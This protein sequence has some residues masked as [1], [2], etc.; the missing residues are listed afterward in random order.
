MWPFKHNNN[1][2]RDGLPGPRCPECK[3]R[4]TR[5]ITHHG[6]GEMDSVKVWRGQRY[7]TCRCLDCGADFYTEDTGNIVEIELDSDT[8]VDDLSALEAAE[9]ELKRQ[10]DEEDDRMFK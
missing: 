1:S 5:V 4:N 10:I 9:A 6:T 3:S 8:A 2:G 7:I